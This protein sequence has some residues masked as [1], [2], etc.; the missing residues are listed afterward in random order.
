ME[1]FIYHTCLSGMY[2][3]YFCDNAQCIL[4]FIRKAADHGDEPIHTG[5]AG[6][7]YAADIMAH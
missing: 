6:D 2:S 5:I 4:V 1:I 3:R 7:M